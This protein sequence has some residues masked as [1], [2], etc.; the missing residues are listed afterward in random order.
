MNMAHGHGS[1]GGCIYAHER[2][3]DD[4]SKITGAG[5]DIENEHSDS[6]IETEQFSMDNVTCHD[7]QNCFHN[8]YTW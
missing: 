6:I 2:T 5:N 1:R 8:I 7:N 4:Q 3:V